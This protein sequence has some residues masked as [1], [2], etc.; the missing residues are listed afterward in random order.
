M[1]RAEVP[2]VPVPS[3][4]AWTGLGAWNLYFLLKFLLL[5]QGLLNL[6]VL[7][8]LLFAGVL[9][10]PLQ[11]TWQRHL[12]QWLALPAG[13]ALFYYDSWLPSLDRLPEL[14]LLLEFTPEYLLEL[15]G[16]LLNWSLIGLLV[17][18][19]VAYRL[20]APWVR[21]SSVSLVGLL[22][23]GLQSLPG[24]QGLPPA[25][26]AKIMAPAPSAGIEGRAAS[27]KVASADAGPVDSRTLNDY[28]EQFYREEATRQTRFAPAAAQAA[29]FDLL[30]LN[31]CSLAWDDLQD[32]GLSEHPLLRQMDV[33]FDNFNSASAY[34][35]PS[36]IRLLR[37]S[38]GQSSHAG[39]YQPPGEQCLLFENLKALGFSGE[40]ALNH[41]GRFDGFLQEVQAE[42]RMPAPTP[43]TAR[44]RH[45]LVGFDGSPIWRDREVL[46]GWWQHR[47]ALDSPRVALFYNSI[48]LHD[49]NRLV[50]DDGR[51]QRADY[52]SRAQ[53]LLD[54]LSAFI[55]ELQR[56]GRRVVLV[57][58][59][60]H[61]AALH[62]DHMQIAGMREIPSPAITHVPVGI[63]LIGMSAQ[64]RSEPLHVSEPSSYLA[65]SELVARLHE[66]RANTPEGLDW[67]AL[68][69]GLPQTPRVAENSGTVVLDYQG[70]TYVRI[71]EQGEWLPYPN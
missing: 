45:K 54:D 14:G 25:A 7:P 55:G 15:A 68:L 35:G 53:M 18:L 62:G 31:I 33:V 12:R 49:G 61:G 22:W 69:G 65:L 41:N 47:Q 1:M 71:K 26:N 6:H 64:P 36:V 20:L 16:R 30:L 57:L 56:S 66:G 51:T 27:A 8:N 17:L 52:R 58:V 37:A 10:L 39:L 3:P 13:V 28:L 44:L 19:L 21:L 9:L 23:L 32:A 60:E 29:P 48:S 50:L 67:T 5:W 59:P 43:L 46:G 4:A 63:K 38:C 70:T 42:G 2:P 34:S 24:F 40:M 11:R